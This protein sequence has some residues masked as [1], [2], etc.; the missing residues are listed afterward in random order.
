M[1]SCMSLA[2]QCSGEQAFQ[3]HGPGLWEEKGCWSCAGS[4]CRQLVQYIDSGT[5]P[6][7]SSMMLNHHGERGLH[8]HGAW[9]W[10]K[11]G[12]M[13]RVLFSGQCV[14]MQSFIVTALE[15]RHLSFTLLSWCLNKAAA[16]PVGAASRSAWHPQLPG[17]L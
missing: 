12:C 4:H 9:Q 13:Y 16:W 11:K 8:Q 10:E 6:V 7:H 14:L 5:M 2:L 3:Q 1:H 17:P 15:G